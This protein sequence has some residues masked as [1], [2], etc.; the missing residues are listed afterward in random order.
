MAIQAIGQR[1]EI[2]FRKIGLS[3]LLHQK[4][5]HQIDKRKMMSYLV[6]NYFDKKRKYRQK[7][8]S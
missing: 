1:I 4:G 8:L 2:C 3:V 5:I 7:F 6:K